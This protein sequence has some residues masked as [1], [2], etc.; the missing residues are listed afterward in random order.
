MN[1]PV[2]RLTI[3]GVALRAERS[4]KGS[5]RFYTLTYEGSDKAGNSARCAPIVLVPRDGGK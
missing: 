5:G 3:E 2:S 1:I 4:G